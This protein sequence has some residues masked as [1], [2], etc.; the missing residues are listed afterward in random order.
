MLIELLTNLFYFTFGLTLTFAQHTIAFILIGIAVILLVE[1]HIAISLSFIRN[2]SILDIFF[3]S[4]K[5]IDRSVAHL[6]KVVMTVCAIDQITFE[7]WRWLR[8]RMMVMHRVF[9]SSF[10]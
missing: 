1:I 8:R 2:V 6:V 5:G 4:I 7:S 10:T 3:H 9:H